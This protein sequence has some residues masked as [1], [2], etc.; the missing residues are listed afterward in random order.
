MPPAIQNALVSDDEKDFEKSKEYWSTV[1]DRNQNFELAYKAMGNNYLRNGYYRE[2]MK[3]YKN[4]DEKDGYSKAFQ[5]IRT[6][7]V[8]HNFFLVIGHCDCCNS[9][10]AVL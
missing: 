8:K 7:F 10:P 3:Y 5:Y 1:L 4:A 2:A 9:P 6:D